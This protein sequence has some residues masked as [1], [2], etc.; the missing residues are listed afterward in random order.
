M[1][2]PTASP[3][4]VEPRLPL[5]N[6]NLDLEHGTSSSGRTS[7]DIT[8]LPPRTSKTAV[9]SVQP[10]KVLE[11]QPQPKFLARPLSWITTHAPTPLTRCCRK[12]ATWI[13]GPVPPRTHRITPFFERAQTYPNRLVARLPRGVRACVYVVACVLWVVLFGTI[14]TQVGSSGNR[15][16]DGAR[17]LGTPIKL[18][19]VASMWYVHLKH[20]FPVLAVLE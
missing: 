7:D 17:G 2:A 18:S 15:G 6:P 3:R 11:P 4:E 9:S 14:I 5:P 8:P 1:T 10:L 13:Q 19:C 20:A 16:E 12:V